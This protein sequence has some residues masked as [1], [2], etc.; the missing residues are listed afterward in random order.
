VEETAMVYQMTMVSSDGDHNQD[1]L[2]PKK[3]EAAKAPIPHTVR[4]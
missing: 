2:V 4:Q 3:G 1:H